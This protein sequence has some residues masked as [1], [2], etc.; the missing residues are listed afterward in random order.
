[1]STPLVLQPHLHLTN[2]AKQ[3]HS[4]EW[5]YVMV[6]KQRSLCVLTQRLPELQKYLAEH[7]DPYDAP[8][9]SSLYE[10]ATGKLKHGYVHRRWRVIRVELPES[11]AEFERQRRGCARSVVLG[12][13]RHL[14]VQPR[15]ARDDA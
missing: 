10:A 7:A 12:Q 14:S 11:A 2:F 8:G 15:G 1:M 4:R 5:A 6:D 3:I 13:A 9:L